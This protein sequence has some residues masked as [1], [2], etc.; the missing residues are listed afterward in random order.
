MVRVRSR[1]QLSATGVVRYPAA[2]PGDAGARTVLIV[3]ETGSVRRPVDSRADGT[4]NTAAPH[5]GTDWSAAGPRAQPPVPAVGVDRCPDRHL[6][7][8]GRLR[9]PRT[10]GLPVARR[11]LVLAASVHRRTGVVPLPPDGAP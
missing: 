4:A 8:P 3:D 11:V 2:T 1:Q 7:R 10:I 9:A 5:A 6:D